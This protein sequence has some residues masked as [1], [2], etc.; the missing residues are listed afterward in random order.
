MEQLLQMSREAEEAA[1]A[2]R[3]RQ[4]ILEEQ[5]Q[6]AAEEERQALAASLPP[7]PAAGGEGVVS[8]S[9]RL[10]NASKVTRRFF[11]SQPLSLVH[12]FLRTL[13]EI[14]AVGSKYRILSN[15]PRKVHEDPT[16]SLASL[17]LGKNIQLIVESLAEEEDEPN[18][19]KQ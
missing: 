16:A 1:E 10:P 12:T 6:K 8:L 18:E 3:E 19:E 13:P 14:Q 2:E 4:R 15:F 9:L 7:E 5:K 17:K 11:D